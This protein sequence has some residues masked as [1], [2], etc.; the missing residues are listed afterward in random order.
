MA[1]VAFYRPKKSRY[2]NIRTTPGVRFRGGPEDF[3]SLRGLPDPN[4]DIGR[5][6]FAV[7]H[8]TALDA[9]V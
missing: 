4:S 8:N 3:C 6:F 9:A 2:A 5:L 1:V 7:R